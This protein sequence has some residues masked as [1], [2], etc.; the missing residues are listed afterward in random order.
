MAW[1]P[2]RWGSTTR[3]RRTIWTAPSS[4]PTSSGT[5]RQNLRTWWKIVDVSEYQVKQ[6]KAQ[7]KV[8][9][10]LLSLHAAQMNNYMWL[11]TNTNLIL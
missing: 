9:D 3:V 11:P 2:S 5:V 8:H 6:E 4:A 10:V 1:I 7:E